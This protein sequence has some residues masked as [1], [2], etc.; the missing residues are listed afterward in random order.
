MHGIMY[1]IMAAAAVCKACI[2]AVAVIDFA[3]WLVSRG[4]DE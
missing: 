3:Y 1:L 4:E 2:V